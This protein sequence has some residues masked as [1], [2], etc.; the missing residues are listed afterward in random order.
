MIEEL[1]ETYGISK[2]RLAKDTGI[3][4]ATISDLCSGK[5]SPDKC[6]AGT[7]FRIA[8]Y[9]GVTV[10]DIIESS[11]DMEYVVLVDAE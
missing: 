4:Q 6:N 5:T 7:L 9:L 8:K 2:Y 1:L 10:E 11:C 3:G